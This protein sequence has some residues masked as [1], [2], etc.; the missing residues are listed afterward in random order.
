MKHLIA[1]IFLMIFSFQV[2]PVKELGKILFK[3][4]IT[5]EEVHGYK[6]HE[7][8]KSL[9]QKLDGGDPYQNADESFQ[10]FAR[11]KFLTNRISTAL[12]A[13]DKLPRNHVPDIV[14]PPPDAARI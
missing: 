7:D 9:K 6:G 8:G 4:Q 10:C 14:T 1:Y 12:H 11:A 13:A 2:L 5:E 3:N